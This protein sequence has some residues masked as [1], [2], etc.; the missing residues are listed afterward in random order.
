MINIDIKRSE[1]VF[2]LS[3]DGS[4]SSDDFR[5]VGSTIDTYINEH[6]ATPRLVIQVSGVPHWENLEAMIAHFQ[7]VR[8]H[9]KIVPKVA[10]VSD[11]NALALAHIFVDH[12][13]GAKIRQFPEDA[14]DDA[15]NWVVMDEDH[16][17]SFIVIEGLPSDIVAIDARGLISSTDY[18]DTLVPLVKAKLEQHE[19]LKMLIVAGPYFDGYSAGAIWD[20]TWFGFSHLTTFSKVALVTD[21]EWLRHAAKL[22]GTLMPTDVMVFSMN[23]IDD[24]KDWITL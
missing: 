15:I 4:V 21:H 14:L 7:L 1:N 9:H 8:D 23:E 24:A 12:F 6:D 11:S 19:N 16:P 18:R 22:F 20:D 2:V 13:T 17:G 3:L 5:N 10:I